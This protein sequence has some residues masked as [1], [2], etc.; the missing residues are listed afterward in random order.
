M[1]KWRQM[2]NSWRSSTEKPT[3]KFFFVFYASAVFLFIFACCLGAGP[4]PSATSVAC[5]AL[6]ASPQTP[7]TNLS[8]YCKYLPPSLALSSSAQRPK[9][10]CLIKQEV[11]QHCLQKTRGMWTN[12]RCAK[13]IW[14]RENQTTEC[15]L[16]Q[17]VLPSTRLLRC[18]QA[19]F[20]E[21]RALC[22]AAGVTHKSDVFLV[23]L[24]S[25]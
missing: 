11:L 24:T 9:S 6:G 20:L 15:L 5:G 23:E 2:W 16:S 3:V 4:S 1:C 13:T 22:A 7:N 12:A 10:I 25:E 18:Q 14:N 17:V 21:L 19:Q 8:S